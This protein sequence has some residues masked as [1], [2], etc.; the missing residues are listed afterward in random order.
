[1]WKLERM[2]E[3]IQ[4][5]ASNLMIRLPSS[6]EYDD[7]VQ[8]GNLGKMRAEASYD[9]DKGASLKTHLSTCIR[10]SMID[11]LRAMEW[12]ESRNKSAPVIHLA[13][14]IEFDVD[15]QNDNKTINPEQTLLKLETCL[16]VEKAVK[17]LPKEQQQVIIGYY[18][19]EIRQ[20]DLAKIM[21]CTEANVSL[22][23]KR[24]LA[25][26]KDLLER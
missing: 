20:R 24:A 25:R 10:G 9:P 21:H 18:F 5:I 1:M 19:H 3:M 17:L 23:K 13:E 11:G 2:D 15:N 7:L 26:L 16:S 14:D 8:Y 12:F 22:I 6:V 4:K